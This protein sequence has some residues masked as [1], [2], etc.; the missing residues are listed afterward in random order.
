MNKSAF[1]RMSVLAVAIASVM[2]VAQASDLDQ[3]GT[4]DK[5]PTRLSTFG[6]DVPTK[7]GVKSIIPQGWQLFVHRSVELP[8]SI[9]WKADETWVSALQSIAKKNQ[10]SIKLDWVKKAVYVRDNSQALEEAAQR[11]ELAQAASTP[12]PLPISKPEPITLVPTPALA[13]VALK[14]QAT[15]A[16]PAAATPL[17]Q[18]STPEGSKFPEKDNFLEKLSS[19]SVV[20]TA[21]AARPELQVKKQLDT[22]SL[23]AYMNTSASPASSRTLDLPKLPVA[24][25][26]STSLNAS[27]VQLPFPVQATLL[28]VWPEVS[29]KPVGGVAKAFN[30]VSVE[31]AVSHIAELHGYTLSFDIAPVYFQGPV[32]TLGADVGE[33]LNLVLKALG[34]NSRVVAELS[35]E[36]RVIR[37]TDG[38]PGTGL[39]ILERPF[40]GV[41]TAATNDENTSRAVFYPE[42]AIAHKPIFANGYRVQDTSTPLIAAT[43]PKRVASESLPNVVRLSAPTPAERVQSPAELAPAPQFAISIGK[44][45]DIETAVKKFAEK[46]G[47]AMAWTIT[48]DG[49]E[50]QDPMDFVGTSVAN[51]LNQFLPAMGISAD[52]NTPSKKITVR[53]GDEALDK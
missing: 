48:G 29:L 18:V 6:V 26:A 7:I 15:S 8:E 17:V 47:W 1:L 50:A 38:A 53:M 31:S 10:I 44:G 40:R 20:D 11:A 41:I 33:D 45:E 21:T 42:T 24:S 23:G 3:V 32:T 52:I 39:V 49:F 34:R 13:V 22:T 46:N 4:P 9:S 12:L 14:P 51:V 27:P 5:A 28:T 30:R 2:T 19:L 35:R 25:P 43:E 16:A 37:I 36:S